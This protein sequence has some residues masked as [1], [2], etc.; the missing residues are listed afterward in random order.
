MKKAVESVPKARAQARTLDP[1]ENSPKRD[2]ILLVLSEL[3]TNAVVHS[4]LGDSN[5]EITVSLIT[6]RD[7]LIVEVRDPGSMLSGPHVNRSSPLMGA[8][9]RGLVLVEDL[10]G[11]RWGTHI[12][13]DAERVVWAAIPLGDDAPSAEEIMI[14]RRKQRFRAVS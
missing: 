1:I 9:G 8:R 6:G 12:S 2:D 11:L 14:A 13:I 3:V 5:S 10:C 4:S 7:V